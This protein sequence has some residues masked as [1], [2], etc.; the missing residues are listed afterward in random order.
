MGLE[1]RETI[2]FTV[3]AML[4]CVFCI[5][6]TGM[7]QETIELVN[8]GTIESKVLNPT[9]TPR[10][11]WQLQ[12]AEGVTVELPN[13][14]AVERIVMQP[15]ATPQYYVKVPFLA[16][17]AETHVKLAEICKAQ[18]LEHLAN[19][20]YQRV[21]ELDPE[22]VAARQALNYRKIDGEWTTLENEM[23]KQGYV[24]DRHGKWTTPQKLM[25]DERRVQVGRE[26]HDS[27]K[28]VLNLIARLKAAP[29]EETEHA[30]Y[31]LSDPTAVPPLVNALQNESNPEFR[32]VFVRALS[33]IGTGPAYY[34][35]AQWTMREPNED[36][37]WTCI[38][39]LQGSPGVA[40][41]FTPYLT[42][43]DNI[44]VN[45]AA[46]V[47]GQLSDRTAILALINAL[48]TEHEIEVRRADPNLRQYTGTGSNSFV[49][50]QALKSEK[51][52]E[53]V[54]NREVLVAL[55]KL[56]N[57]D[58]GYDIPLWLDWWAEQ[59]QITNFDARRGSYDH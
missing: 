3:G 36:V 43:A 39:L 9:E 28:T 38:V 30:L 11:T 15:Q 44:V 19:L 25:I 6:G 31:A 42:N 16:E 37:C 46:Y 14:N 12:M 55:R 56:S 1:L 27:N 24:K 7:S 26:Y 21:L 54:S 2:K 50:Q 33:H 51:A 59:N 35:I 17:S 41:F 8:G 58:F 40:K 13:K 53:L 52:K 32:D 29:S 20:H 48:I 23:E 5:S 4:I 47:L 22:N 57:Q 49:G 45:R 10:M 18:K 34:E